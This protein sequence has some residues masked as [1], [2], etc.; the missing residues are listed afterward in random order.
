MRTFG[1]D[2]FLLHNKALI[3]HLG[4]GFIRVLQAC[5]MLSLVGLVLSSG[6]TTRAQDQKRRQRAVK[7]TTDTT[8]WRA[9]AA[10]FTRGVVLFTQGLTEESADFLEKAAEASPNSAG[11]HYY[12]S[13]V[14]YAQNDPIRMLIHAEKAYAEASKELWIALGYA[15]ALQLNNQFKEACVLLEKLLKEYPDQP[16]ILL[17]LAQAY[18]AAGDVDKADSYYATLQHTTGNYEEIFHT[19][20]QLLIEKGRLQRAIALAESL[21]TVFPRH[22]IYLETAIRLYELSRDLRG[23]AS[24]ASRL[25]EIDPASAVAWE[26]VMSYPEFFEEVWGEE[27]WERLLESPGTPTEVKYM[28]LRRI[29]FLDEDDLIQILRKLLA[30]SPAASGW[31]L[32]ARYWAYKGRWD[33]AASAW[34]AAINLDSAQLA[35]YMDYFYA[36]WKLGGGDS[37]L[38]EVRRATELLPGQGRLYLWEAIALT[39]NHDY[40]A[41]LP[42]FQKGWRLTQSIDS[43]QAQIALYYQTIAEAAL[44]R[45]SPQTRQQFLKLYAPPI[46]EGLWDLLIYRCSDKI[47]PA[48]NEKLPTPYHEWRLLLQARRSGHLSQAYAHAA[49]AISSNPILPLEMWEDILIGLGQKNIGAEYKSWKKRA[50]DTYPLASL[51]KDL[52]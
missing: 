30:E 4:S 23:M 7:G 25:L 26:V 21:S 19:R 14:A 40:E 16:E 5:S 51:W 9:A 2:D 47:S 36:L 34:K 20:V 32:Y 24:V 39:L 38:Y 8:A 37:L 3:S 49:Q 22:E 45:P 41:A 31:D 46:G 42:L 52:P 15:A 11:T 33:S 44:G 17:R 1:S 13:R 28:L 27:N 48:K 35:L 43:L 6:C 12:L 10:P 18:Q 29:E 50:Q